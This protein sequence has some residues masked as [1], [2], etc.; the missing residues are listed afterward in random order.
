M[1]LRTVT[2]IIALVLMAYSISG[3]I[4]T[5]TTVTDPDGTT[6]V[7]KT[8]APAPGY[9]AAAVVLAQGIANQVTPEK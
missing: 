8:T 5:T 4:T 2:T 9:D 1:K 6:T 7:T 3:C